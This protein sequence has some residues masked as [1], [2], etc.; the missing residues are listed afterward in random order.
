MQPILKRI[1]LRL[2]GALR[3]VGTYPRLKRPTAPLRLHLGC[4]GRR[5][6]GFVNIDHNFSP[7]TDYISDI[8]DLPCP[9]RSVERI[10]TYHVIEHIPQPVVADMLGYWL[11]LL[12]PGATLVVEC[13]DLEAD[14]KEYLEG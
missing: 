9:D 8:G 3:H 6:P 5:L 13:P 7:A 10:E 11:R 4:G 12:R 1:A 14:I 2:R